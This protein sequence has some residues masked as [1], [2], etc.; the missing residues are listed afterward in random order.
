MFESFLS[1]SEECLSMWGALTSPFSPLA[2]PGLYYPFFLNA[3]LW[4]MSLVYG[5]FCR[6]YSRDLCDICWPS[7]SRRNVWMDGFPLC[8]DGFQCAESSY[9]LGASFVIW[10]VLLLSITSLELWRFLPLLTSLPLVLVCWFARDSLCSSCLWRIGDSCPYVSEY[11]WFY[12][13]C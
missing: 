8:M 2:W 9:S 6:W 7:P 1:T 13:L 10:I 3:C 12:I 5:L 11:L 4:T